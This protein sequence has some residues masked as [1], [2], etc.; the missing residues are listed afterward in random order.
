MGNSGMPEK[1]VNLLLAVTRSHYQ[2]VCSCGWTSTI[3]FYEEVDLL[4][5]MHAHAFVTFESYQ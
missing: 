4:R 2:A 1:H 5:A 3:S